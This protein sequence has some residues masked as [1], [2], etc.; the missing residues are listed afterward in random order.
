MCLSSKT[1]NKINGLYAITDPRLIPEEK[2]IASVEQAILGGARVI[3]YRNKLASKTTQY[4]QAGQLSTLCKQHNICFIINDDPQL[5][6]AVKANGVH[7]GKKDGQIADARKQ[8]GSQAIIGVSCYNQLNNA[9]DSI[10]QGADYVAFGRFFPSKTKPHA[11][12]ADLQLLKEA[13]VQL[14]VPIVAI[15]GI[16]RDNVQQLIQCGANSVAVI[17]DLFHNNQDIYNTAK[18]YQALFN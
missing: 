6:K 16:N 1:I 2:L 11:V 9:H 8:L 13:S 17:N 10:A 4:T 15:G 3:Q 7:V 18:I 12:Q 14:S 5:A